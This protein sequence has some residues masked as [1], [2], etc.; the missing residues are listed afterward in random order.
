V[1]NPC[2]KKLDQIERGWKRKKVE[3]T[4]KGIEQHK[5][6]QHKTTQNN[7]TQ[8]KSWALPSIFQNI[9]DCH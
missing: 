9:C 3:T 2:E 1:G 6:T 5:T 4:R 7:A 8:N